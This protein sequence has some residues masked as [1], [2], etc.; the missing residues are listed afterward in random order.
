MRYII[1][2]GIITVIGAA[3][4]LMLNNGC[5]KEPI[6]EVQPP[7]LETDSMTDIDGNVYKTVKI[8]NQWWMAE[9]LRVTM[10]SDS[11]FM[12]KDEGDSDWSIDTVGGSCIYDIKIDTLGL[13]YNWYAV[14]STH[15][16]APAGW[17][18]PSDDEWKQLEIYLGMSSD[19]A[20]KAGWRGTHEGEKLKIKAPVSWTV[21]GDVWATNESGF[22]ALPASCREFNGKMGLPGLGATGFW[23]TST[24]HDTLGAY[25]RY[26]DYKNAN[27]Y[28][29]YVS[30]NDGFSV[31]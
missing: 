8:G 18:I 2:P 13:L 29:S 26:L 1:R 24:S 30:K 19:E 17:H 12:H 20:N 21:Y 31:R 23:W 10:Y 11:T 7:A 22:T 4:F 9:N 28:R 14:N 15:K 5:K 25:F 6:E 3:L 27:V 16:L